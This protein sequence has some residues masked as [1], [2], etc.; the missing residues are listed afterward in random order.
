MKSMKFVDYTY[1]T[2]RTP[3]V[4]P[5][6]LILLAVRM[7]TKGVYGRVTPCIAPLVLQIRVFRWECDRNQGDMGAWAQM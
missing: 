4:V 2:G 3:D 5:N 1:E 7:Q 6:G